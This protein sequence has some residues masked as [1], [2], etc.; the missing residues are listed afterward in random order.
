MVG[1]ASVG[2]NEADNEER[3]MAEKML[4]Y[5]YLRATEAERNQFKAWLDRQ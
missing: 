5:W 1:S 3:G 2:G 4:Q